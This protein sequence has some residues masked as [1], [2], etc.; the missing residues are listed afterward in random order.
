MLPLSGQITNCIFWTT[1]TCV[2]VINQS[3][4]AKIVFILNKGKNLS[5]VIHFQHLKMQ[6]LFSW[7]WEVR[8]WQFMWIVSFGHSQ[9]L[10]SN[11]TMDL[12]NINL[13]IFNTKYV[14]IWFEYPSWWHEII[15]ICVHT[16]Y[17]IALLMALIGHSFRIIAATAVKF[18]DGLFI[19]VL[20]F[21]I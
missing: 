3:S 15:N 20:F 17:P 21:C 19:Q 14:N 1:V 4:Y 11:I 12:F 18:S 7:F 6:I 8:H 9:H 16:S 5:N 13:L 2:S 10:W